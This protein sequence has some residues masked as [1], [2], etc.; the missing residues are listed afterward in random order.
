VD[1][2]GILTSRSVR[3]RSDRAVLSPH[4]IE[5]AITSGS[6]V[7][8]AIATSAILLLLVPARPA[9]AGWSASPVEVRAG[10]PG[11][12]LIAAVE[13][14]RGGAIV[15]WQEQTPLGAWLMAERLTA[16]GELDPTWVHPVPFCQVDATRYS[17]GAVRDGQ[18]GAY[19]WWLEWDMLF[20][21]RL[22]PSGLIAEGFPARGIPLGRVPS[23]PV[24][25]GRVQ[26]PVVREDGAGGVALAWPWVDPGQGVPQPA[27]V[28]IVRLGPDGAPAP[29]W[30]ASGRTVTP[31]WTVPILA[32]AFDVTPDGGSWVALETFDD[33]G[34]IGATLQVQRLDSTGAPAN[35][36]EG[37]PVALD[38]V[39]QAHLSSWSIW[40]NPLAIAHGDLDGA[41]LL[42][43][44]GALT[45]TGVE[46]RPRLRRLAADGAPEVGW[47]GAGIDL[48][49]IPV[50]AGFFA[51]PDASARAFSRPAGVEVGLPWFPGAAPPELRYVRFTASGAALPGSLETRMLGHRI[52]HRDDGEPIASWCDG[53]GTVGTPAETGLAQGAAGA[54][55]VD[56]F[57]GYPGVT[58][59]GADVAPTRDGGAILAWS[60]FLGGR[61]GVFA[62]RVNPTGVVTSVPPSPSATR[63]RAWFA[64]G[65]GLRLAGAA[66]RVTLHD[67]TGR[68]IASAPTAG[69]TAEWT[70]PGTAMLPSGMYFVRTVEAGRET[71]AKVVVVR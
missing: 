8:L 44:Y 15:A 32:C 4:S 28:R 55:F 9:H 13:D 17:L 29:G 3:L 51:T 62:V 65:E 60:Q 47:P 19:L 1:S 35:G 66:G 33:F 16:E 27:V 20:L 71:R 56:S 23:D 2:D 24:F 25:P 43:A 59:G 14:A 39:D 67:L 64:R 45:G 70:L 57:P 6:R 63:L 10:A 36:W 61:Q 49:P 69:A 31:I 34:A 21:T 26:L 52:A 5:V 50:P 48:A 18:G 30:P 42:V 7:A 68:T 54:S 38:I 46:L 58:Y 22:T 37:G 41:Y 12:T 40:A 53:L 11:A